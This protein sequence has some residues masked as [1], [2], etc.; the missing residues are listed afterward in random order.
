[1]MKVILGLG[2]Q[3]GKVMNNQLG[4][5]KKPSF[6][7]QAFAIT[8]IQENECFSVVER[9]NRA[10]EGTELKEVLEDW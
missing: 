3:G 6:R 5:G 10:P 2:S 7:Q 1:M 4:V 8:Q 9:R